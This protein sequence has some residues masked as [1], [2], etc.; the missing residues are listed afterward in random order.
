MSMASTATLVPGASNKTDMVETN[1]YPDDFEVSQTGTTTEMIF[2]GHSLIVDK[3]SET[4][5]NVMLDDMII[6]VVHDKTTNTTEI[7]T[8]MADSFFDVFFDLDINHTDITFGDLPSGTVTS[9]IVLD[10]NAE[11]TTLAIDDVIIQSTPDGWY[12]SDVTGVSPVISIT[13]DLNE[14]V[15]E[16]TTT[17]IAVSRPEGEVS[18]ARISDPQ[19]GTDYANIAVTMTPTSINVVNQTSG[20]SLIIIDTIAESGPLIIYENPADDVFITYDGH[21][22][23]VEYGSYSVIIF[24]DKIVLDWIYFPIIIYHNYIY[25]VYNYVQII[26]YTIVYELLLVVI[27]QFITINIFFYKIVIITHLIEI[28]LVWIE[29]VWHI[30]FVFFIDIWIIKIQIN[31][32]ASIR[33]SRKVSHA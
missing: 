19:E 3:V 6:S 15:V 7:H 32:I 23:T 27:Y 22:I 16:D 33:R 5:T 31:I 4:Q 13:N 17:E 25:I 18:F 12:I 21:A 2:D 28:T 29:Y 11:G 20:I 9:H 10:R 8:E 30:F 14:V 1:G 24:S 26:I